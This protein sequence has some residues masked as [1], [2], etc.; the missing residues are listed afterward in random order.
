MPTSKPLVLYLDN[1]CN[2]GAC[3]DA[4]SSIIKLAA[5]PEISNELKF[6]IVKLSD[7]QLEKSKDKA[8]KF[9][10]SVKSI[11]TTNLFLNKHQNDGKNHA[12]PNALNSQV[13][14]DPEDVV[15]RDAQANQI[16]SNFENILK[17]IERVNAH[18]PN[19]ELMGS[20]T[21]V[22]LTDFPSNSPELNFLVEG[23]TLKFPILDG[24]VRFV[25][26]GVGCTSRLQ[27]LFRLS[28]DL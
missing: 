13:A 10:K 15:L 2:E 12:D 25:K 27:S 19:G 1:S 23:L 18:H 26:K 7:I 28:F 3:M 6:H 14:D 16:V 20:G 21:V 17:K 4:I 11:I 8:G 22:L 24:I 5:T 9:A